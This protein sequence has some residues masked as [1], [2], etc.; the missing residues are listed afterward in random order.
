MIRILALSALLAL[1]FA[2][3]ASARPSPIKRQL[4]FLPLDSLSNLNP[5]SANTNTNTNPGANPNPNDFHSVTNS[6]NGADTDANPAAFLSKLAGSATSGLNSGSFSG[7]NK[8]SER[9]E[10]RTAAKIPGFTGP[11]IEA[12]VPSNLLPSVPTGRRRGFQANVQNV[13]EHA[14]VEKRFVRN[15]DFASGE[16]VGGS[17]VLAAVNANA[18]AA[19]ER[20]FI[21]NADYQEAGAPPSAAN[22][23]VAAAS[24]AE[25]TSA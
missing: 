13:E 25:G 2:N 6:N 7:P 8:R 19:P 4:S 17:D 24:A 3:G 21:R 5:S 15:A 10:P 20:R 16:K 22:S 23:V 9:I 1:N 14:S 12:D 18:N 11:S